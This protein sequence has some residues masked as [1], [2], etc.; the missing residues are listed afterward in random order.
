MQRAL[1]DRPIVQ[2]DRARADAAREALRSESAKRWPWLELQA[3]YR[4]HDQSSYA[5]DVTF[6]LEI[7]L[8]ILDGNP[9]PIAAATARESQEQAL[10]AA[11]RLQ[12][13]H[14]VRALHAES[15]RRAH[16]ADRYAESMAPV[17]REHA[18]LVKAALEGQ[19]L[20]L[21]AVLAAEDM[22]TQGGIDYVEAR[23]AE[24]QA[25]IALARTLGQYGRSGV[26][27]VE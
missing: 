20:D 15:V 27:G 9:G 21:M 18:L 3:R 17:L 7:T 10:G 12:I 5:N 26:E 19:E 22:V 14:A 23:L 1:A 2:A 4:R 13:Q 11:H 8:P 25:N 6:G 16:I 24:R